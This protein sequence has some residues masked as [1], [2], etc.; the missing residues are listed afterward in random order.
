VS[1]VVLVL[2]SIGNLRMG[3]RKGVSI[4]WIEM[5]ANAKLV[6]AGRHY[7]HPT[8]S[9]TDNKRQVKRARNVINGNT[10]ILECLF[11]LV[12]TYFFEKIIVFVTVISFI[13]DFGL[14][15][16]I[17]RYHDVISAT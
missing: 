4:K 2:V 11:I 9:R 13:Q 17:P 12:L 16:L 14:G 3:F 5:C 8:R 10:H 15:M 7:L 1:S 6:F